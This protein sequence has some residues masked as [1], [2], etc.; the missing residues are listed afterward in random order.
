MFFRQIYNNNNNNKFVLVFIVMLVRKCYFCL[1]FVRKSNI[2]MF[3]K[4]E[5]LQKRVL[6]ASRNSLLV[7]RFAADEQQRVNTRLFGRRK[8]N[9][10]KKK[11]ILRIVCLIFVAVQ[12]IIYLSFCML[13]LKLNCQVEQPGE[14]NLKNCIEM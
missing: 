3:E 5:I 9:Q 10:K 6:F 13:N 7:I 12:L 14:W 11:I 8:P 1:C 2:R 4:H